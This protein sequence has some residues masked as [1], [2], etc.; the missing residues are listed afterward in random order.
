VK[1]QEPTNPIVVCDSRSPDASIMEAYL[2]SQAYADTLWLQPRDVDEADDAVHQN[3]TRHV[4]FPN[5]GALLD[6]IWDEDI[7]FDRWLSAGIVVSFADPP[8]KEVVPS[9]VYQSWQS[10]NRRHK[11]RQMIAGLILSAIA[12]LAGLALIL[13]AL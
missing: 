3:R 13:L 1:P 11:R 12:V 9:I 7:H 6:A 2:I 4:I 10:W 5:L 8:S